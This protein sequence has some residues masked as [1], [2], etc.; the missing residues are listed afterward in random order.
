MRFPT[1]FLALGG[2]A[3]TLISPTLA[4]PSLA[5]SPKA[6]RFVSGRCGFHITQHQKNDHGNGPCFCS[7]CQKL[8]HH[9][10]KISYVRMI[11]E[12]AIQQA[13]SYI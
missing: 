12:Y 9:H 1:A 10:P 5:E 7:S 8:V 6:K 2:I 11:L 4:L 13:A 3:S